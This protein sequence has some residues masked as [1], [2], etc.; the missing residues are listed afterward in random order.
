[1]KIFLNLL[2]AIGLMTVL[3][4]VS[5][6]DAFN[7]AELQSITAGYIAEGKVQ[8]AL[9][10]EKEFQA[11]E[12]K[13]I[14]NVDRDYR[15]DNDAYN[16]DLAAYKIESGRY[17]QERNQHAEQSSAHTSRNRVFR[18]PDERATYDAYN[19]EVY[20]LNNWRNKLLADYNSLASKRKNLTDRYNQLVKTY[21]LLKQA[22]ESLNKAVLDWAAKKKASNARLQEL[23]ARYT[24]W[25]N[26]YQ[27]RC[28]SLLVNPA[29]KPEALKH[30]CGN[31][32]FD[33]ANKNLPSLDDLSSGRGTKFFGR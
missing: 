11:K 21:N 5:A 23:Q 16:A 30:G 26:N 1:M 24:A 9:E 27:N 7:D 22:R 19:S 4:N 33:G 2:L 28:Q 12:D 31:I 6:Q 10:D 3:A 14:K 20:R 18:L 13:G 25:L 29:T 15:R 17:S 32:Q 8:K